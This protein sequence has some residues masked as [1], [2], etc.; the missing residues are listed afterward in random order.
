[1]SIRIEITRV[2]GN[3]V[4]TPTTITA[5]ELVFWY[6]NDSF[7]PEHAPFGLTVKYKGTS[8]SLQPYSDVTTAP[9]PPPLPLQISYTCSV[10]G[11]ESESGTIT[12]YNNLIASTIPAQN[13]AGAPGTPVATGG[14]P[15][16]TFSIAD[17]SPAGTPLTLTAVDATP[18]ADATINAVLS[19]PPASP[20]AVT[21]TLNATDSMG[22][23]LDQLAVAITFDS[24]SN[25]EGEA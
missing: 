7:T 14:K 25:P 16:Y 1:M 6:N 22:N 12:V 23:R 20:L 21:F 3:V 24:S 2:N 15:P 13:S 5:D 10:I 17:L 4:F 11:H 9:I 19:D 8:E 18:T